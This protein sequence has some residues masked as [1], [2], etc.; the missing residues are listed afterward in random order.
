MNGKNRLIETL[1]LFLL[2]PDSG[3]CSNAN[4]AGVKKQIEDATAIP[5]VP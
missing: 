3:V 1:Q 2:S 5:D 4:C